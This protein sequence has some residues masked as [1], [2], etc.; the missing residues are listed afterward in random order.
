MGR[1][2][3]YLL[4][5]STEL[6][7]SKPQ[8]RLTVVAGKPERVHSLNKPAAPTIKD[9]QKTRKTHKRSEAGTIEN[10]HVPVQGRGLLWVCGVRGKQA[11]VMEV[12]NYNEVFDLLESGLCQSSQ[13]SLENQRHF[14]GFCGRNEVAQSCPTLC[15]PM[16]CSLHQAPP[17]MGFSRQEYWSG[18]PFPSPGNLPN[19]GIE[20]RSPAL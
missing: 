16:D 11:A 12:T 2:L 7:L 5:P 4:S 14:Q 18:L 15:D 13:V 19:P 1:H 8:I 20:P 6:S 3:R 9:Q 17:S 10:F